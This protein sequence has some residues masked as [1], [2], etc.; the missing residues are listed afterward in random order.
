MHRGKTLWSAK[1]IDAYFA[2]NAPDPDIDEWYSVEEMR[3]KFGMTVNAVYSF[4]STYAIPRKKKDGKTYYSKRHVDKVKGIDEDEI[5]EYYTVAEAM[6]KYTLTRDQVFYYVKA[7]KIYCY[8][9][10]RYTYI[11]SKE[12]DAALATPQI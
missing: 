8:R 11:L 7:R 10:G 3:A 6:K 1:H 2:K 4:V 9:K 5:P 12:F